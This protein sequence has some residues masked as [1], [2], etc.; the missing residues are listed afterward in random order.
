MIFINDRFDAMGASISGTA[1]NYSYP[2]SAHST[3]TDNIVVF[4]H[5]SLNEG[6]VLKKRGKR[7][8]FLLRNI[9]PVA[10]VLPLSLL[11]L[12]MPDWTAVFLCG[13]TRTIWYD[14]EETSILFTFFSFFFI[15]QW[16]TLSLFAF[17]V[18]R[19]FQTCICIFGW[20]MSNVVN[21]TCIFHWKF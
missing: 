8:H 10:E 5:S 2:S 13:V 21:N 12:S 9:L 16:D 18:L 3:S 15:F 11:S 14:C 7:T 6:G 20:L 19:C 1:H 17:H 4:T